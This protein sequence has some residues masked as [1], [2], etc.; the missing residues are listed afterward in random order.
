[1]TPT[2]SY[3]VQVSNRT[4]RQPFVRSGKQPDYRA[5]EAP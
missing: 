4:V 5:A 1:M 3:V 2:Q